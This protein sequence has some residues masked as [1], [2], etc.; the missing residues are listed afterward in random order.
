MKRKHYMI[1]L[2][3]GALTASVSPSIVDAK[4]GHDI[5]VAIKATMNPELEKATKENSNSISSRVQDIL[6]QNSI[7]IGTIPKGNLYVPKDTPITLEL[8]QPIS[9]KKARKI[10]HLF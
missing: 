9:S 7:T 4:G 6:T 8:T 10:Q 1:A 5:N 3:L 2:L